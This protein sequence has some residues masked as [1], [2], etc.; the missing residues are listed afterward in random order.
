MASEEG[1]VGLYSKSFRPRKAGEDSCKSVTT[2]TAGASSQIL[3]SVYV[4]YRDHAFFRNV[5]SPVVEAVI[6]EALGWVKKEN[7]EVMLIECDRPLLEGCSGFNGVVILKNCIV[8][9]VELPLDRF[10]S[11]TLNCSAVTER[12]STALQPKE[13]KN[14][15]LK[16]SGRGRIDR[17][18]NATYSNRAKT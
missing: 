8:S 3:K 17:A 1:K 9:M 6:R 5:Q 15:P 11:G 4:R 18:K 7:D 10:S 14:S 13:A 16:T 2:I 12:V